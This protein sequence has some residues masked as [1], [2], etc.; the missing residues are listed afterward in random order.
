[1]SSST[2]AHRAEAPRQVRCAII[3]V[4]DTRTLDN[5][6]GGAAI[7]ERLT[8]NGHPIACRHITRDEPG[9]MR[10]LLLQLVARDDVDAIL[11]TGGTGLGSRDQTCETVSQL[12]TKPLPGYGEL[13]RMLSFEQVGAAAMLS[14]A[15][16]GLIHQTI[17]LT[18]PGSPNGVALAMDKLIIPELGH[19]RRE[20]LK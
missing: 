20:A 6:T 12:L 14:R 2:Q 13:L 9:P 19:L 4:S 7:V 10:A 15:V 8:D 17:V 1:M 18:M 5:D 3:T 11:M 16:G